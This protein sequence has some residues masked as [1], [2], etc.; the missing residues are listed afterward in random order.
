M[1]DGAYGLYS[2][3]TL[4]PLGLWMQEDNEVSNT[5]VSPNPNGN[6]SSQISSLPIITDNAAGL[7]IEESVLVADAGGIQGPDP[8]TPVPSVQGYPSALDFRLV[9]F[10]ITRRHMAGMRQIQDGAGYFENKKIEPTKS[11]YWNEEWSTDYLFCV[12]DTDDSIDQARFDAFV[13]NL[14]VKDSLIGDRIEAKWSSMQDQKF[15]VAAFYIYPKGDQWSYVYEYYTDTV[16]PEF[17]K[18]IGSNDE[19]FGGL[20]SLSA[21]LKSLGVDT[22]DLDEILAKGFENVNLNELVD[23]IIR[24]KGSVSDPRAQEIIYQMLLILFVLLTRHMAG[25]RQIQLETGYWEE[26]GPYVDPN[27]RKKDNR[28]PLKRYHWNEEWSTDYLFCVSDT[29]DSI[30]QARFDAFVNNLSVKDP[31]IGDRIEA[32]WAS[33][34][35]QKFGEGDNQ[36]A[37]YIYPKGD[38]WSY[39]YE[40]YAGLRGEID[41]ELGTTEQIYERAKT[42]NGMLC[43]ELQLQA[44]NDSKSLADLNLIDYGTNIS[45][46]LDGVDIAAACGSTHVDLTGIE[47]DISFILAVYRAMGEPIDDKED[48]VRNL[49]IAGRSG[50]PA[51][52]TLEEVK[53]LAEGVYEDG[54][55]K[56]AEFNSTAYDKDPDKVKNGLIKDLDT[57]KLE[58]IEYTDMGVMIKL[59]EAGVKIDQGAMVFLSRY[60]PTGGNF[61]YPSL[62][63]IG[64][65]ETMGLQLNDNSHIY[66]DSRYQFTSMDKDFG[67]PRFIDINK[68]GLHTKVGGYVESQGTTP[69]P[70]NSILG[71]SYTV[72]YQVDLSEWSQGLE[73]DNGLE[74]GAKEASTRISIRGGSDYLAYEGDVRVKETNSQVPSFVHPDGTTWD[75][76]GKVTL[77]TGGI[78]NPFLADYWSGTNNLDVGWPSKISQYYFHRV[79][80]ADVYVGPEDKQTRITLYATPTGKEWGYYKRDREGS[81]WFGSDLTGDTSSGISQTVLLDYNVIGG[82]VA[83]PP[84]RIP[85]FGMTETSLSYEQR[86]IENRPLSEEYHFQAKANSVDI[87]KG[88]SAG[89]EV[90]YLVNPIDWAEEFTETNV[91]VNAQIDKFFS[92]DKFWGGKYPT[93]VVLGA[94]RRTFADNGQNADFVEFGIRIELRPDQVKKSQGDPKEQAQFTGKADRRRERVIYKGKTLGPQGEQTQW[95]LIY[96]AGKPSR[97]TKMKNKFKDGNEFMTIAGINTLREVKKDQAAWFLESQGYAVRGKDGRINKKMFKEAIKQ[98]SQEQGIKNRLNTINDGLVKGV[99]KESREMDSKLTVAQAPENLLGATRDRRVHGIRDDMAL[100]EESMEYELQDGLRIKI[101]DDQKIPLQSAH[102]ISSNDPV[103]QIIDY[104]YGEVGIVHG[105]EMEFGNLGSPQVK[106]EIMWLDEDWGA[107]IKKEFAAETGLVFETQ[108]VMELRGGIIGKATMKVLEKIAEREGVSVEDLADSIVSGKYK[109]NPKT[110]YVLAG[111]YIALV[112]DNLSKSPELSDK[113]RVAAVKY[114][115]RIKA[116]LPRLRNARNATEAREIFKR[117]F[118]FDPVK[119]GNINIMTIIDMMIGGVEAPPISP[120]ISAS[121]KSGGPGPG[122][123][124]PPK[125][126]AEPKTVEEYGLSSEAFG[127]PDITASG[128]VLHLIY[129][130]YED[131]GNHKETMIN[132]QIEAGE[133]KKKEIQDKKIDVEGAR[134]GIK[135]VLDRDFGCAKGLQIIV[136]LTDKLEHYNSYNDGWVDVKFDLSGLGEK[137]LLELLDYRR[138]LIEKGVLPGSDEYKSSIL[139]KITELSKSAPAP[140]ASGAEIPDNLTFENDPDDDNDI[141]DQLYDAFLNHD[142]NLKLNSDQIDEYNLEF[143]IT[144]TPEQYEEAVKLGIIKP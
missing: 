14:T 104:A 45:D 61:H 123:P 6:I 121:K 23:E 11:Y 15:G 25:V 144:L 115:Q 32:K 52:I 46:K 137:E 60:V 64:G 19:L 26:K 38:Q 106:G 130:S 31:V 82:E 39:V 7:G 54:N 93:Y 100:T 89:A 20:Q 116:A 42:L 125:P 48:L 129:D 35:D 86:Q 51:G 73:S 29:D 133:N 142:G 58:K 101:I 62:G 13:N 103:G 87:L 85:Y 111:E 139:D 70:I 12:S 37:F 120:P 110:K 91:R 128:D 126:D 40:Y 63:R 99:N 68:D 95:M 44:L 8:N 102:E 55:V 18:N 59:D 132:K 143:K 96:G 141:A 92:P 56:N 131:M 36:P 75:G 27:T 127:T 140:G 47:A 112:V 108:Y 79:I 74:F 34:Q 24:L 81:S 76:S 22:K 69:K 50:D 57:A 72:G 80:G 113:E 98:Y 1:V 41:K 10:V 65:G 94:G 135:R 2:N 78:V 66:L 17:N 77:R 138:G 136:H 134:K 71:D 119:E 43:D 90:N 107:E 49:L 28:V 21:Q 53:D 122:L 30:D 84:T 83:L 9:G 67:D 118:G 105:V 97:R 3:Y 109:V 124:L 16:A 88:G 5:H 33:M 114:L 117:A 4:D